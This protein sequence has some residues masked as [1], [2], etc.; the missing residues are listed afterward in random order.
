MLIFLFFILILLGK[1][2]F[3]H[4]NLCITYYTLTSKKC[5]DYINPSLNK[6]SKL[7]QN[8]KVKN[9]KNFIPI[10]VLQLQIAHLYNL[11]IVK[12]TTN[13]TKYSYL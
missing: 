6:I 12:Q 4:I 2:L 1:I 9:V 8:K 3:I 7:K 5:E 13:Q 10:D 11:N